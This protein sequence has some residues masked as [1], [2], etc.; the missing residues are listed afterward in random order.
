MSPVLTNG[1]GASTPTRAAKRR[2]TSRRLMHCALQLCDERGFDGWTV[3]DLA[4]RAEVSRRTVFNYYD[5]K[6]DIVLGPTPEV[7]DAAVAAFL[8]GQ[9]H[10]RLLDDLLVLVDEVFTDNV[11][12]PQVMTL[13]QEVIARDPQLIGLAHDRFETTADQFV[14]FVRQREGAAYDEHRAR[15]LIRLL[16]AVFDTTVDRMRAEPHRTFADLFAEGVTHARSL[17]SG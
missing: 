11:P 10:G 8:A 3:D 2:E 5:G 17:L 4:E 13:A 7:S 14:E 12:D 6:A 1:F 15:L 9:P 16:I